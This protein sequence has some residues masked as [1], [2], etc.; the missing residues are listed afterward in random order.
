[1]KRLLIATVILVCSTALAAQKVPDLKKVDVDNEKAEMI[2]KTSS[3]MEGQISEA[4]MK[5]KD[6]QN[7]TIDY[8]KGNEGTK[9]MM[10]GMLK[11]NKGGTK[12]LMKSVLGDEKLSSAA[13]GWIAGDS[14]MMK[15]VQSL[16]GK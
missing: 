13:I 11:N 1:M 14:K 9:E 3:D 4:L 15:K 16:M 6:L 12:E 5:D 2:S 8:L 10:M 7:E